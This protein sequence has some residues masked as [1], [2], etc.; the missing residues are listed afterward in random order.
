MCE[1]ANQRAM[2]GGCPVL[3]F[4]YLTLLGQ[5]SNGTQSHADSQQARQSSP[6]PPQP[7][8]SLTQGSTGMCGHA[9][10]FM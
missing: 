7:L 3:S 4:L 2:L 1:W 9:R 6:F 5:G 8:H 10:L